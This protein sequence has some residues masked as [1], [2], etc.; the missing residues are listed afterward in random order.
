MIWLN[1]HRE[2]IKKEDPNLTMCGV[3]KR[4][5]E[6]WRTIKDKTE[7]INKSVTHRQRYKVLMKKFR[8]NQ[9]LNKR[10]VK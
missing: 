6:L 9:K 1:E 5:G 10:Q 4:G 2:Q 3:S 8:T 7:W